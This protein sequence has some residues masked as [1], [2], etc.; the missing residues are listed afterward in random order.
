MAKKW[1]SHYRDIPKFTGAPG[2]M[3]DTHLIKLNDMSKL[4]EIQEPVNLGDNAQ[5]IIDLFKT[6]LNGPA[7]N[8][9]ELNITDTIRGNTLADWEEIKKKFLQYYNP[10]GST[11]EQ[12][13]STL[14][15]LKWQQLVETIDQF[16]YKFGL[17]FK[18]DFGE[19]YT[20]AMFKRSLPNEY[21]ERLMGV[22]TFV[23]VIQ[24]VKEVQQFLGQTMPPPVQWAGYPV[25]WQYPNLQGMQYPYGYMMPPGPAY[26][27]H[28]PGAEGGPTPPFPP[29]GQAQTAGQ[30]PKMNIMA[31][32][33][34]SFSLQLERVIGVKDALAE[35]AGEISALKSQFSNNLD[36][37]VRQITEELKDSSSFRMKDDLQDYL[38][39]QTK[40]M[41]R[42]IDKLTKVMEK[43]S[44]EE[45]RH[46]DGEFR[47]PYRDSYREQKRSQSRDGYLSSP[48]RSPGEYKDYRRDQDRD[49][50]RYRDKE[51]RRDRSRSRDGYDNPRLRSSSGVRNNPNITCRY[52]QEKG[53]IQA[54]CP[55]LEKDLRMGHLR[56]KDMTLKSSQVNQAGQVMFMIED[57]FE[58]LITK[59]YQEVLN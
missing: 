9:Y 33:S 57:S 47:D 45:D 16:A 13:M 21:K 28:T 10:A 24:R 44:R 11:I 34:V 26:P 50:D 42:S 40:A 18:S 2:E 7:R 51:Y 38:H 12:Q 23:D 36:L 6:S 32:K 39:H 49:R 46:S 35:V 25:G 31:A 14:D 4:F 1:T 19:D 20:V 30:Q 37:K 5:E 54:D 29:Q 48:S 53:H 41:D 52:C 17:M 22:N 15:T 43:Y 56:N 55:Q 27:G 3:G 58:N 8:W 59:I